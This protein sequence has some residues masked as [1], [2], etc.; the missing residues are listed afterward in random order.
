MIVSYTILIV[1]L[2]IWALIPFRQ[3]KH[4]FFVFFLILGLT[5]PVI[6]IL[7][8]FFHVHPFRFYLFFF[9]IAACSLMD[10]KKIRKTLPVLIIFLTID[11]AIALWANLT[12]VQFTLFLID[13][14]ILFFVLEKTIL[15]INLNGGI[16]FFYFVLNFYIITLLVKNLVMIID[17]KTGI[18]YFYITSALEI[19]IGLYFVFFNT[20]NSY[21]YKLKSIDDGIFPDH[22]K[23]KK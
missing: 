19:L 17:L 20:K 15:D 5:D 10:S 18:Y 21:V 14:V 23:G 4:N 2:T 22:D 12:I 11:T 6:L 9:F 16:N 1:G 7:I 8:K 13:I 3:Y